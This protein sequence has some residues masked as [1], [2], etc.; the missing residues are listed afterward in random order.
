MCH[1]KNAQDIHRTPKPANEKFSFFKFLKIF[2]CTFQNLYLWVQVCSWS[3]SPFFQNFWDALKFWNIFHTLTV[4][5][6]QVENKLDEFFFFRF[7]SFLGNQVLVSHD[8]FP[9]IRLKSNA[10]EPST[11]RRFK[12]PAPLEKFFLQTLINFECRTTFFLAEVSEIFMPS[13]RYFTNGDRSC[14][15]NSVV[16]FC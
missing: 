7:S 16:L 3:P 5:V 8:I 1:K 6:R 14:K 10:V 13:L 4:S 9:S 11:R 12:Q 2:T 15:W